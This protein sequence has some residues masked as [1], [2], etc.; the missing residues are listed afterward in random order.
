MAN[1]KEPSPAATQSAEQL[2]VEHFRLKAHL[3]AESAKF[4]EFCKP[5]RERMDEIDNAIL[6][7]F[8]TQGLD[9]VSCDAGTAYKSTLMNTSVTADETQAFQNPDGT[10]SKGREAVLDYCL[11]NWDQIGNEL[12][13][14]GVQK[15]A[16]KRHMEEHNGAPPPGVKIGFFSRINYR[17]S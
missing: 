1:K 17:K 6:G 9:K 8:N 11:A 12:L 7:L 15:D 10:V 13:M 5:F 2:I 3:D 4:T 14:I 16:V